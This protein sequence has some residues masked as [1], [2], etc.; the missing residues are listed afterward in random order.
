VAFTIVKLV[1]RPGGA[2]LYP[3]MG[4]TPQVFHSDIYGTGGIVGIRRL[5]WLVQPCEGSGGS[6][7]AGEALLK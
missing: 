2:R 4:T 3:V 1:V 5:L 6:E 7:S